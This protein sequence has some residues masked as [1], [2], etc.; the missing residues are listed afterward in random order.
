LQVLG[1]DDFGLNAVVTSVITIF[2]FLNSSMAG[3]TSRFLTFELGKNDNGKLKHPCGV[4]LSFK[5]IY[6]LCRKAFTANG[7]NSFGLIF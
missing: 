5:K 1:T 2:Y 4:V 7:I 6:Y 3:A